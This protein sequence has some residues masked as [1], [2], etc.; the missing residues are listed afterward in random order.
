MDVTKIHSY[1]IS[2]FVGFTVRIDKCY[3]TSLF[4]VPHHSLYCYTFP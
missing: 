2:A 4:E 1:N 3:G